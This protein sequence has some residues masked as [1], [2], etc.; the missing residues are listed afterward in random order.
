M[1][2]L[3][4]HVWSGNVRELEN[5]VERSFVLGRGSTIRR[6]DLPPEVLRGAR[7]EGIEVRTLAEMERQEA[8]RALELAG[9][10][11]SQAA[12]LLG[13]TRK[14]LYRIA[15]THGLPI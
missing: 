3:V 2:A 12:R 4:R 6:R 15:R 14:R 13:I 8:R 5:A 7:A 9:G 10:N 1:E 11:I